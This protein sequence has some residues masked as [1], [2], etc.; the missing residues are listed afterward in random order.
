[1]EI[2]GNAD[3]LS[4]SGQ[5]E[6]I[7]PEG[8]SAHRRERASLRFCRSFALPVKVEIDKAEATLRDGILTIRLPKAPELK[9]RAI[10]V[11]AG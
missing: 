3:T 11:R 5:R 8:W 2:A 10:T 1:V 7:A 4:L 9:P 6:A